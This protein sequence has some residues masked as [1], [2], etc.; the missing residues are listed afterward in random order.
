MKTEEA[1]Q[2]KEGERKQKAKEEMARSRQ[3]LQ[4]SEDTLMWEEEVV[5]ADLKVADELMSDATSKLH[6]VL[7]ATAVNKQTINVA[8]MILDTA[9]PSNAKLGEKRTKEKP[10]CWLTDSTNC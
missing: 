3:S 4:D 10:K 1:K 7:S 9:R 5:K 6:D 8:T 2:K